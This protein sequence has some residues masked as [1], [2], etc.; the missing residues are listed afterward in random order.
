MLEIFDFLEGKTYHT[1]PSKNIYAA[2]IIKT[3]ITQSLNE[4][5]NIISSTLKMIVGNNTYISCI[6][7]EDPAVHWIIKYIENAIWRQYVIK[8]YWDDNLNVYIIEFNIEKHDAVSVNEFNRTNGF[9]PCMFLTVC[10]QIR[11]N[12]YE[13]DCRDYSSCPRYSGFMVTNNRSPLLCMKKL[14]AKNPEIRQLAFRSLNEHSFTLAN[15]YCSDQVKKNVFTSLKNGLLNESYY[16]IKQFILASIDVFTTNSYFLDEFSNDNDFLI[17]IIN[18]IIQDSN[19]FHDCKNNSVL[20]NE[21][22]LTHMR[23]F[24]CKS[25]TRIGNKYPMKVFFAW[26]S[27]ENLDK[28]AIWFNYTDFKL[29]NNITKMMNH[30]YIYYFLQLS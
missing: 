11:K 6:F 29:N 27:I 18:T 25:L 22:Y 12:I 1:F 16:S 7:I 21:F 26:N 28:N 15:L 19:T 30:I 5:V 2:N 8:I 3:K 4:I 24:A 20:V 17:G 9:P 13:E 14:Y 23:L 10:D